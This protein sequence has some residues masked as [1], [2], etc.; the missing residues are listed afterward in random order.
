MGAS[1]THISGC[2][3]PSRE[4]QL[5]E[6]EPTIGSLIASNTIA[7]PSATPVSQPSRP[8]TWV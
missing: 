2:R 6:T 4:R 3:R 8:S 5:S 7:M 1:E